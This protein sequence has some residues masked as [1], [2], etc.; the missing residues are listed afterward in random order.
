MGNSARGG[1]RRRLN[2]IVFASPK[3]RHT[4]LI[5]GRVF[6]CCA[7][8]RVMGKEKHTKAAAKLSDRYR[9]TDGSSFRL[10]DFDPT[11]TGKLHD[12][13][14]ASGLLDDSIKLLSRMQE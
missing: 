2:L 12:K 14:S 6:L 13:E 8:L 10:K 11:D 1:S 7:K 9:I 3:T 4:V 5:V